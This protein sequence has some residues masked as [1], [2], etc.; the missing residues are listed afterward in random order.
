ME[1]T[2]LSV[3]MLERL[4]A[5]CR[6][7]LEALGFTVGRVLSVSVNRRAKT[8]FGRCRR[9]AGGGYHIEIMAYLNN[10]RTVAEIRQTVMHELL[11]TLPGCGNH[12]AGFQAAARRVNEAL[13]YSISSTS[14][15]SKAVQERIPF[16]YVLLCGVCGAE[17]KRYHRKPRLTVRH[18]HKTCGKVSLGKLRLMKAGE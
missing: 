13:G 10:H 7:E 14:K 8:L 16:N 12:G 1:S 4:V 5:A 17:L 2:T 9:D 11:H 18:Y 3:E 6:D 15:L